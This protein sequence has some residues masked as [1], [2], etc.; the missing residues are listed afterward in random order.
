MENLY[1]IATAD[2][3]VNLHTDDYIFIVIMMCIRREFFLPTT[4]TP[5]ATPFIGLANR[6]R[7]G[8]YTEN[9]CSLLNQSLIQT[10]TH[11]C[12]CVGGGGVHGEKKVFK[13]KQIYPAF[14]LNFKHHR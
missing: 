10:R 5:V 3:V 14:W 6:W 4:K 9:Y 1:I 12:V 11:T 7:E 13:F 2:Y 8:I